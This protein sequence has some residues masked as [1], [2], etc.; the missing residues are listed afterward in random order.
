[1]FPILLS[2]LACTSSKEVDSAQ[3]TQSDLD[4]AIEQIDP[5]PEPSAVQ[6]S[7]TLRRLT[8]SQYNNIIADVFSEDIVI[9]SSLEPDIEVDGFLTIGASISNISPVG[10]E[11]YESASYSI[12]EQIVE[13]ET[14]LADILPC[15]SVDNL[16]QAC[17]EEFL[18]ETG[19][20]LWRRPIS[21][22]EVSNLSSLIQTISEQSD[23]QTGLTYLLSA[24]FQSPH[25]LYRVE[26]G[27]DGTLSDFEL[28]SRLSFLIWNSTPDAELLATAFEGRLSDPEQLEIE[29]DRMIADAKF[30]KGLR[31]FFMELFHLYK[32]DDVVKDPLVFTHA[33]PDLYQSAKEETLLFLLHNVLE[34]EDYRDILTS[35]ET[36]VDRRLAALY[37][38]AAP[39]A[40]DFGEVTL[41]EAAGRRGLLMQASILNLNAHATSTSATLRGIFIRKNLLCQMIPA[42]P[43]NVDTSIPEADA[44]SPTLRERLQTHLE[45]PTCSGCHEITDLV[46]LGFE[47][48]D[49]IGRWRTTENDAQ[50][51]PSGS[52][53]GVD[54]LDAWELASA[55]KQHDNLGPCVSEKLYQYALGHQVIETEEEFVDW[56]ATYLAASDW[57]FQELIRQLALSDNFKQTGVNND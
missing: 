45:D 30:E 50:I 21:E 11:R 54:F 35:Q 55:V 57:S 34:K 41:S 24:L 48:F 38:I 27:T 31:N 7:P 10:I 42:P 43:A 39:S 23:N 25:F 44:E 40:E 14:L 26:Q 22:T 3:N 32:L 1:M 2:Y 52:I 8:I 9:P 47:T 4:S 15:E 6:P 37:N 28:A 56:M 18:E 19:S 13:N 5:G 46:G 16:D 20:L 53:D 33:S 12:A 36:F 29:V 17:W 51:D 49:G